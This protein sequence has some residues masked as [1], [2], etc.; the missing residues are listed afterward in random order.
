MADAA[1][2]GEDQT[3]PR[4][5]R[6]SR[7]L[8]EAMAQIEEAG[9]QALGSQ[10][11][12]TALLRDALR[13]RASDIH[14]DPREDGVLVRM[15]VDGV[16]LDTLL[17][18]RPQAQPLV[19]QL[20]TLSRLDPLPAMVPHEGRA[21]LDLEGQSI[22]LRVT[23]APCVQGDKLALRL[24][25]PERVEYRLSELGLRGPDLEEIRVWL[26][27]TRGLFLVAGPTGG[28]K[29]TTLYSLLQNL[30]LQERNIIT[31]EDPVEYE[32]A[33]V[34][35]I[36][37]DRERGPQ[38]D[39]GLRAMLRLDP[40][41]L[42]LGEIRDAA[43]ARAAVDAAASGRAL[44]ST[45]HSPDAAGVIT[46]LRNFGLSDQEISAHLAVV[47][48]QR[49][50]R[51]LCPQ[52]RVKGQPSA[53]AQ[54]WLR[55]MG[56]EPAGTVWREQGCEACGGIGYHGRTGIFEVW[57]LNDDDYAAILQ[58]ADERSLRDRLAQRGHMFLLDD[59]LAKAR[60]GVTTI[61]ELRLMGGFGQPRQLADVATVG[62]RS[63][64]A[65]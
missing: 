3:R 17:L 10:L 25:Q 64:D 16:V 38:L 47:V 65:G 45:V 58:H 42:L 54:R 48:A 57:H 62:E 13:E 33:G 44:M 26:D 20:K 39:E 31:I 21:T 61:D 14:L 19:N 12:A 40:D 15:R 63:A 2:V 50:V 60:E 34:N 46:V 36:Q 53:S 24:L 18:S 5:E 56:V 32:V 1:G 22:D 28:G 27:N 35:Q 11:E 55:S 43:A 30:K 29:T 51:K 4:R 6:L 23:V 9:G 37:V 8:A 52:C 59:G 7:E 41:Y 49:L